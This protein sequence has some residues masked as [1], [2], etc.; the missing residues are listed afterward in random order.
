MT[1]CSIENLKF[2]S[3]RLLPARILDRS[4][5]PGGIGAYDEL[6]ANAV[7]LEEASAF[8]LGA[9]DLVPSSGEGEERV[10]WNHY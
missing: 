2:S 1:E 10:R 3:R 5:T 6:R 8:R 9:A 7:A 4:V